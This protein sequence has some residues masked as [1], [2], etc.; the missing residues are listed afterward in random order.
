[1]SQLTPNN[2]QIDL[3]LCNPQ[4]ISDPELLKT[5]AKLLTSEELI[6]QQRYKFAKHRHDALITRAFVRT[7]LANYLNCDPKA[8]QFDKGEKDKPY[9]TSPHTNLQFNVSHTEG[10]IICGI[11][12]QTPIGVDVEFVD[13]KTALLD[14]ADR[15]FSPAETNDLFA[16]PEKFQRSAFFDYW[17][18]K[19]SFIK[20]VGLGL[21]IPLDKFSFHIDRTKQEQINS[22]ISLST[23]PELNEPGELFSSWLLYP[24][25]RH[26]IAIT[27]KQPETKPYV[28]RYFD[29]IPLHRVT[30]QML[31]QEGF[32]PIAS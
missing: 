2:N 5:Y 7:T 15:Y 1:M 8:I 21:S 25:D 9:I 23:A 17:T 31:S 11:T 20:A 19:E 29:S 4:S 3:W 12:K 28:I 32:N 27:V 30:E 6:R 26:R 13:R 10:L 16:L 18:L 22:H 24:N 14:I